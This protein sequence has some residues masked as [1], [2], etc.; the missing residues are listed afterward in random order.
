MGKTERLM[1]VDF[2]SKLVYGHDDKYIKTKIKIYA[3]SM[4]TNFHNNKMPKE[5]VFSS[6]NKVFINFF[7]GGGETGTSPMKS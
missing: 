2:E 3:S 4:I 1:K 7:F 6:I 5:K